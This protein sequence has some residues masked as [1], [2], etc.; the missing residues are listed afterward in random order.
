MADLVRGLE[1]GELLGTAQG[2]QRELTYLSS[3]GGCRV[4]YQTDWRRG[5]EV[6]R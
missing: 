3:H 2:W 4:L 1:V 5:S 6:V